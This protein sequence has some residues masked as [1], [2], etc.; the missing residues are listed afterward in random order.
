MNMV[1]LQ[2]LLMVVKVPIYVIIKD[3]KLLVLILPVLA[4]IATMGR[5]AALR[6]CLSTTRLPTRTGALARPYPLF[7]G[8]R[9]K[10]A[11]QIFR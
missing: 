7:R 3:I 11:S 1:D 6:M 10:S 9:E 8:P 5:V 2:L 4:A